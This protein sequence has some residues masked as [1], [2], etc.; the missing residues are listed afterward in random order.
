MSLRAAVNQRA[1]ELSVVEI[2]A[3]YAATAGLTGLTVAAVVQ[4]AQLNPGALLPLLVVARADRRCDGG[5]AAALPRAGR[6]QARAAAP[7]LIAAQR[8]VTGA[9]PPSSVP[10]FPDNPRVTAEIGR[11]TSSSDFRAAS[12]PQISSLMPP[13]AISAAPITY[14][15]NT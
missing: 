2:A 8:A 4:L 1:A 5:G 10:T 12:T 15:R 13:T 11:A 9:V 6:G 14:P 7:H 3:A